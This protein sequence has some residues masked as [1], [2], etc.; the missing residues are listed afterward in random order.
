MAEV[1]ERIFMVARGRRSRSRLPLGRAT[2]VLRGAKRRLDFASGCQLPLHFHG[3]R[4]NASGAQRNAAPRFLSRLTLR[5]GNVKGFRSI[6]L[7]IADV[8]TSPRSVHAYVFQENR[9]TFS[10]QNDE[11]FFHQ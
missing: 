11:T 8:S 3:R 7:S 10:K 6:R 4:R 5:V 9:F 1:G 2:E